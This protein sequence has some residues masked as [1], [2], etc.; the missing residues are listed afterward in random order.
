MKERYRLYV[1][2]H[3]EKSSHHVCRLAAAA[4]VVA[5]AASISLPTMPDCHFPFVSFPLDAPRPQ[6]ENDTKKNKKPRHFL[7]FSLS[8]QGIQTFADFKSRN[9]SPLTQTMRSLSLVSS[10]TGFE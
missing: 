5:A 3:L 1:A 6:P 2:S 9:P 7:S 10:F 4:A 8:Y